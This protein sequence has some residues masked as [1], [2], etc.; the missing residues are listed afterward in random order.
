[1]YM[2]RY[3]L[4]LTGA[5][6]SLNTPSPPTLPSSY[7]IPYIT[8]WLT[9]TFRGKHELSVPKHLLEWS[10]AEWDAEPVESNTLYCAQD[11]LDPPVLLQ[12]IHNIPNMYSEGSV[13]NKFWNPL[14]PNHDFSNWTVVFTICFSVNLSRQIIQ[15]EETLASLCPTDWFYF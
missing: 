3:Q 11:Q 2:N 10:P 14:R 1:M 13:R 9:F 6:L 7:V 15:S 12:N 4:M 5:L 8:V